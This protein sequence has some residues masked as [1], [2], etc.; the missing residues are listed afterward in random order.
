MAD[1]TLAGATLRLPHRDLPIGPALLA[2]RPQAVGIQARQPHSTGLT[3]RIGKSA[4]LGSHMEYEVTIDGMAGDIFVINN[5]V[6]EPIPPC[7]EV[8]I[9]IAPGGAAL[10]S[11]AGT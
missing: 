10:V 2:V 7:A 1:V 8:N 5:N 11:A 9:A 3:G 6:L 4:Y